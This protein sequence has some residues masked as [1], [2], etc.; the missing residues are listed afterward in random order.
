MAIPTHPNIEVLYQKRNTK[1]TYLSPEHCAIIADGN[2]EH[3]EPSQKEDVFIGGMILL[4]C[5]LLDWQD[6]CY[7]RNWEAVNWEKIRQKLSTVEGKY[8]REI[9]SI[10]ERMLEERSDSRIS[11]HEIIQRLDP[12]ASFINPVR[13]PVRQSFIRESFPSRVQPP[14]TIQRVS[15][16]TPLS[17]SIRRTDPRGSYSFTYQ[18]RPL[19]IDTVRPMVPQPRV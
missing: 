4:D 3:H 16:V 14:P 12:K 11:W 10:L 1:N 19:G 13:E 17:D 9:K 18:N 15:V 6:D 8:G 7:E 5:A 2:L